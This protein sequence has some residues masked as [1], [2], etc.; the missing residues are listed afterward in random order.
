[1]FRSILVP[2]D[3]STFA[4]HALPL[5]VSLAQRSGG[6]LEL[7]R[8]HILYALNEP[9]FGRLPFDPADEAEWRRQEQLYLDATARW[10]TAQTEVPVDTALVDGLVGEALLEHARAGKTDLIV[11]TTHSRGAVARTLLGSIADE[12]VRGAPIPV[13]LTRP[14]E[15]PPLLFPE[16]RLQLL[17]VPLDGSPLAERA[18]EP[19]QELA[20]LLEAR[21]TLLRVVESGSVPTGLLEPAQAEAESYLGRIAAGMREESLDVRVR[22]AV[23]PHAAE[24]IAAEAQGSDLIVLATHGRGGVRRMILGSVADKVIRGSST[25]VLVCRAA[26]VRDSTVGSRQTASRH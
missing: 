15:S 18:L 20:R 10:L 13:L 2:L 4:E 6:R 19:A 21:C 7:V 24:A 25:P 12:L 5:A 26:T 3:G 8:A 22:V 1:M 16:P 17:L 14:C 9:Y 23:A 11:M